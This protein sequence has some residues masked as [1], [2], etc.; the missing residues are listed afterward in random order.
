MDRPPGLTRAKTELRNIPGSK[1]GV[2]KLLRFEGRTAKLLSNRN[3]G[4]AA[5]K[6]AVWIAI[7]GVGALGSSA[8]IAQSLTLTSSDIKEGGRFGSIKRH[9]ATNIRS[10]GSKSPTR[11]AGE[12]QPQFFPAQSR[13]VSFERPPT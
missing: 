7:L 10:R 6:F 5:T 13:E 12:M 9:Q 11:I 1:R 8:A 3:G 2:K 4:I